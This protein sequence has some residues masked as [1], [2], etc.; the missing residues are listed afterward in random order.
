MPLFVFIPNRP[1]LIIRVIRIPIHLSIR[2][3]N[4]NILWNIA[5]K[6]KYCLYT[7]GVSRET[8]NYKKKE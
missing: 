5:R 7:R 4:N 3:R 6:I 8:L 2:T 1:S